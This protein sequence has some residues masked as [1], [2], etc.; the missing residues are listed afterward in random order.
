[1]LFKR[2]DI[3]K[4]LIEEKDKVGYNSGLLSFAQKVINNNTDYD[5]LTSVNRLYI[6]KLETDKIYHVSEIKN[7]CI[8]YRL[9]FLDSKYYKLEIPTEAIDKIKSLEQIHKTT[10]HSFKIMA[11]AEAL[12][13]KNYDDP[14]LFIPIGN[15]YYYLIHKWGNDLSRFRKWMVLPYK[16]LGYLTLSIFVVSLLT[17][18]ILPY[19]T[20]DKINY[21]TVKL[22]TFLFIFKMYCAIFIYYFFWK[23][24]QFSVSNWNDIYYN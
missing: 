19:Q 1:M 21:E 12:K 9:R 5:R 22:V 14:L 8:R 23:G 15:D 11:T 3:E 18:F 16:N 7:I 17:T 6:D 10:L 13:L 24:K 2:V 4:I 20:F